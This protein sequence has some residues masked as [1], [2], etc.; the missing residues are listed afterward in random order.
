LSD[1]IKLDET[2]YDEC[3]ARTG[4]FTRVTKLYVCDNDSPTTSPSGKTIPD[5]AA[6]Q[7]SYYSNRSGQSE[8][9]DSIVRRD[10]NKCVFCGTTTP[11]IAAAHVLP[12]KQKN[13]LLDEEKCIL[14]GIHSIMDSSNGIALC[15]DCHTCFDANLVCID[16]STDALIVTDALLANAPEKW[17]DLKNKN[18]PPCPH[19]WPNKEL[20]KFREQAMLAATSKR[21]DAQSEYQF[22]C[23]NCAKGY[24]K[25]GAL[26]KHVQDCER[27]PRGPSSYK[28]PRKNPDSKV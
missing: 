18:V 20:L 27:I 13:V 11:P 10:N 25:I 12:V 23:P 19:W 26:L 22:F 5:E 14:Y 3:I 6:S 8:F 28:T 1:R 24:K 9:R 2:Q 15:W 7:H 21:N 17:T 4:Y 16:P